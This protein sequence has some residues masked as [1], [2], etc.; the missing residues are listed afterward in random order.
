MPAAIAD[1]AIILTP[2]IANTARGFPVGGFQARAF[3]NLAA[4]PSCAKTGGA[5]PTAFAVN[6]ANIFIARTEALGAMPAAFANRT[7]HFPPSFTPDAG[8]AVLF[9]GATTD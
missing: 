4:Q 2:A 7:V 5:M 9:A 6:A 8:F 3:A 1:R